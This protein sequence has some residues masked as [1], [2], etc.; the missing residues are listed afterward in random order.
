MNRKDNKKLKRVHIFNEV[1]CIGRPNKTSNH[2]VI[3]GPNNKEYDVNEHWIRF[4][5]THP[6]GMH[7]GDDCQ[8]ERWNLGRV[9]AYILSQII[10][11][12]NWNF[13][14]DIQ[15]NRGE[16]VK[17]IYEN[18]TIKWIE[19]YVDFQLHKLELKGQ[20]PTRLNP[21]W[22]WWHTSRVKH[23]NKPC[24]QQF[25]WEDKSNFENVLAWRI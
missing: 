3:Y 13:D 22:K 4:L 23:D 7:S 6:S 19:R 10:D 8:T 15:P 2:A 25:I 12:G 21:E 14:L 11:P 1:W 16:R 5:S 24:P 17:V 18:G 20:V 9:K